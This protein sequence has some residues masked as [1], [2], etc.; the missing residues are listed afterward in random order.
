MLFNGMLFWLF[1]TIVL[2]FFAIY[3]IQQRFSRCCERHGDIRPKAV[4]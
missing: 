2:L 3:R 1:L 4:A